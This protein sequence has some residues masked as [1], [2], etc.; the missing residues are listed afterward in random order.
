M[1]Q[2]GDR[3]E[4]LPEPASSKRVSET[5]PDFKII[6]EDDDL[7]VVDKPPGLVVHP[8]AGCRSVTLMESLVKTR[9]QMVGVG[10]EKRWG[11][12]HRLDKDTS[13]VMVVAKTVVAHA[14]LSAQ[15][16]EHSV[17]RIYLALV[18]ATPT[19]NE[20][21]ID[22]PLGRHVKDRKKISI[23]TRKARRALTRWRIVERLDGLTLLAVAPQTGRTHQIRVH[24]A[25][26]G[27]PVAGDQVYGTAGKKVEARMRH[28][29]KALEHIKRQ[30][31]H[32][33]I[34]GFRRPD[35]SQYLEFYSQLPDDMAEV[36]RS[37]RVTPQS[38]EA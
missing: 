33:A 23:H 27:M 8:A 38:G 16:K 17:H 12:V 11:I 13:G 35:D 2:P 9:P 4:I 19:R 21:T 30:A 26:I 5:V 25:S 3:I 28:L 14:S 20:G 1:L 36:I 22:V 10:E 32:A 29:R 15:F 6:F 7:I 34:L 24:L 31:L 18:R 37:L